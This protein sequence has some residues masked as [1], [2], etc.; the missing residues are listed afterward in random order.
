MPQSP[1][2][3]SVQW[4]PAIIKMERMKKR[5]RIEH[6]KAKARKKETK[7]TKKRYLLVC[8]ALYIY[9]FYRL[10]TKWYTVPL[11]MKGQ[12][13]EEEEEEAQEQPYKVIQIDID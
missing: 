8:V 11:C 6:Q 9:I 12:V 13:E 5:K 3:K 10:A 7:Q 2:K 1:K 4:D